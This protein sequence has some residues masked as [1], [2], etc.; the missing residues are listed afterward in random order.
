MGLREF[1]EKRIETHFVVDQ[2]M[3]FGDLNA[4]L[5]HRVSF[6]EGYG[7]VLKCLVVNGDTVGGSHGILTAVAFAD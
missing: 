5:F 1:T 4:T 6:A 3:E 2:A 7:V